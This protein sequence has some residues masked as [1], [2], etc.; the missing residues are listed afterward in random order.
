METELKLRV[1]P[2]AVRRVAS[3]PL[4]KNGARSPVQ[5]LKAVYYD[6]PNLDL[7][8]RGAALR[9]RREGARWIQTVKWSGEVK[10]GLHERN[11]LE[12]EVTGPTPDCSKILH[13][14]IDHLFSPP[15]LTASLLPV[16]ETNVTRSTRLLDLGDVVIEAS[17]D[18]GEIKSGDRKEQVSELELELKRG[19][20]PALFR[21]GL[22]IV[23]S[24]PVALE[25]RSKAERGYALYRD[26]LRAPLKAVMPALDAG[27]TVSDAFATIAWSTLKHLQGN[28]QGFLDGADPEFL[29][30]MRVAVRRLRSALSAFSGA[31]P[32]ASRL[33]IAADLKWL[34]GILGPARDWDVFVTETLPLIRDA[35]A[36]RPALISLAEQSVRLQARAQR[37][38]HRAIRSRRYQRLLIGLA[39]W[40]GVQAWREHPDSDAAALLAPA[41]AYAQSELERRYEQVRKRGRKVGAL[42]AG[43]LHELRIAIKKLRYS[44]DFFAALFNPD[45]VRRFR[46]RLSRLQ[47]VLGTLNDA[48]TLRHLVDSAFDDE[49]AA[50]TAEARGIVVGWSAG[51][52]SALKGELDR[53]WKGF[54][55]SE[56]YW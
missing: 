43:E 9:V 56:T 2:E 35:F 54:R 44:V 12:V 8:R 34:G 41:R 13:P 53:F 3:H 36:E 1:P 27:V 25:N 29:H 50:A 45:A 18:R 6:T 16:F 4:L 51:R 42:S 39:S 40:L 14:D 22:D 24:A 20:A 38:A 49:S 47:D 11:E 19:A 46:S 48:A 17:F 32:A 5:K 7:W 33:P 52:A 21:A 37:Q 23:E 30:Q 31:L 28:E 55:R 26:A 10:A 15:E